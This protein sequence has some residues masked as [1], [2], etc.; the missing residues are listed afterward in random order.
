VPLSLSVV[1]AERTIVQR[2]D[3]Q[4]LIVPTTEGQITVLPSTCR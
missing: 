3:V 4:R 2:G 1:T